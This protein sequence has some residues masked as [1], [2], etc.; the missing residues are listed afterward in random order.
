MFKKFKKQSIAF[1]LLVVTM[2]M[3]VHP[4]IAY[5]R[6]SMGYHSPDVSNPDDENY[7]KIIGLNENVHIKRNAW[8]GSY[9]SFT[10]PE[11]GQYQIKLIN[12]DDG[13]ADMYFFNDYWQGV[14]IDNPRED[15]GFGSLYDNVYGTKGKEN[16]TV[17]KFLNK[18]EILNIEVKARDAWLSIIKTPQTTTTIKTPA[19]NKKSV[20]FS[21]GDR[22]TLKI[23][24]NKKEVKWVSTNSKVVT[25]S[26]SGVI[27]AKGTGTAYVWAIVENK[28][29]KCK[30]KVSI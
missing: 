12:V 25:V 3:G 13:G 15:V 11:T 29:Y 18:D 14:T 17:Y 8:L 28:A 27:K 20:S 9:F 30:V 4:S 1:I 6:S 19:I 5:A 24:Y 26:K 21:V 10:A 2:F 23:K 7:T 16:G 22:Q